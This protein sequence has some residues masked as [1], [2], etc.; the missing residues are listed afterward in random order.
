MSEQVSEDMI[1]KA[2]EGQFTPYVG[3]PQYDDTWGH[4]QE[5]NRRLQAERAKKALDAKLAKAKLEYERARAR[6]LTA[7]QPDHNQ[8]IAAVAV[9]HNTTTDAI[10]GPSRAHDVKFARHHAAWE[11]RH[12]KPAFSLMKIGLLLGRDHSTILNS[13]GYFEEHRQNYN[14][15]IEAVARMLA[16]GDME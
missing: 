8:I 9:V 6:R 2:L 14:S 11:L 15:E 12:R 16:T 3:K 10:L 4:Q 1:R 5:R 13:L 7:A